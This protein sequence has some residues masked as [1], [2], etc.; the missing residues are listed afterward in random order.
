MNMDE[1]DAN[2]D[3]PELTE[4]SDEPAPVQDSPVSAA[5]APAADGSTQELPAAGLAPATLTQQLIQRT[6]VPRW[7][8]LVM[9]PLAILGL[10]ELARGA[11]SVLIVFVGAC[12]VALILNPVTKLFQRVVPR[13]AAIVLAY[14]LVLV[15]F[16]AIAALISEPIAN[17][18]TRVT[19]NFPSFVNRANRDLNNIQ[20]WLH[21]R[22]FKVQFANQ[23]HSALQTIEK[24]VEKSSGTI[25]SFSRNVL[26]KAV[27]LGADLVIT[28]VLSIYL[29]IYSR[30]IGALARRLMPPGDG[31]PQDDYPLLV[32]HAVS[33]YVRGQI[34]FS[35]VMGVSAGV[36]LEL[37]GLL[38]I[39]HD[40]SKF[41]VFFGSFYGLMEFIPYIGPILGPIP[42]IIVALATQPVAALW[43]LIA[44]VLL[45]QLEGHIVAPQIFRFSLRI[46]PILVIL[47]LLLGYQIWGIAG[48]LLALPVA[49]ILRQTVVYL[50]RH[51]VLESW[52]TDRPLR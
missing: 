10:W 22:G 35:V 40:G 43:I 9:L 44:S 32:Q 49:T 26:T 33:G 1:T 7:V 15:I 45:Q 13:G 19:D 18:V 29:L 41:A 37:M 46:N 20:T 21:H 30:Q 6:M 4:R 27:S 11:G 51:L 36:V 23:G 38:G 3:S 17:Q 25:V 48:A 12:V 42:P 47:A 31:T 24:Q 8:Q 2:P 14:I 52:S 34:A 28:F 5:D 39:F 16:A 50:R